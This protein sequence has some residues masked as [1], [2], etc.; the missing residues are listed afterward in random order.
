[1]RMFRTFFC[2]TRYIRH[3]LLCVCNMSR[4]NTIRTVSPYDEKLT[5][6]FFARVEWKQARA[7]RR[8]RIVVDHGITYCNVETTYNKAGRVVE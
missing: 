5:C 1:M 8:S 7:K 6:S 3:F 2:A 4:T